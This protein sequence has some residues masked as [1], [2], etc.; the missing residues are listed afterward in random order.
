MF[1]KITS[2]ALVAMVMA[3]GAMAADKEAPK[4]AAKMPMKEM[5]KTMKADKD[6]MIS[7][8]QVMEMER[9]RIEKKMK[10]MGM[11]GDKMSPAE[12]EKLYDQLYRGV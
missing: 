5:V 11:K 2:A 3:G 8:H 12:W 4:D 7:V 10:D 1:A 9:A 6:G